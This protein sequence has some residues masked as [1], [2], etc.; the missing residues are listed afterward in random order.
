[1]SGRIVERTFHNQTYYY[2]KHSVRVKLDPQSTGKHAGSGKSRVKTENIYLGKAEDIL[3]RF[4]ENKQKPT[5]LHLREFGLPCVLLKIAEEIRLLEIINQTL[6]YKVQGISAGEFILIS[7]INK[8]SQSVSK[9]KT[10]GWFSRT[11]LPDFLQ[12]QGKDLRGCFK[13]PLMPVAELRCES[14]KSESSLRC[15]ASRLRNPWSA[16][17][18]SITRQRSSPLPIS[19]SPP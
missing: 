11:V 6:P 17:G 19:I 2:Y 3:Q 5:A 13:T 12:I 1:M 10:G 7:A 4:R 16:A 18:N 15:C 8:V 9:D 14:W